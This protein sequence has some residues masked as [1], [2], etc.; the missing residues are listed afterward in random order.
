MNTEEKELFFKKLKSTEDRLIKEVREHNE[1]IETGMNNGSLTRED[2]DKVYIRIWKH[3]YVECGDQT[4]GYAS[5]ICFRPLGHIG[6]HEGN[7]VGDNK[8][9]HWRYDLNIKQVE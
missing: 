9:Y 2:V 1:T 7:I 5:H 3:G 4:G 8:S 6:D